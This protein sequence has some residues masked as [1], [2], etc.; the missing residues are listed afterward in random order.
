MKYRNP[1]AFGEFA[2]AFFAVLFIIV[3]VAVVG[4]LVSLLLIWA[5]NTLFPVLAIPYTFWT[6]L[7]GFALLFVTRGRYVEKKQ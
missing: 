6:V 4:G 3:L 7:A 5:L 2:L 1:N